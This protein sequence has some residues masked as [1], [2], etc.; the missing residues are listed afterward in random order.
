MSRGH[1]VLPNMEGSVPGRGYFVRVA[2]YPFDVHCCYF[3]HSYKASCA[4]LSDAVI[5]NF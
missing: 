2:L 3:M 4:I 5:C 1:N